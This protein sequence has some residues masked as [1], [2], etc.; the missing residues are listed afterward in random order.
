MIHG[1]AQEGKDPVVLKKEWL[2][3]LMYGLARANVKLPTDTTIEFPFYGDLLAKLVVEVATPLG[4]EINAKGPNP[5]TEN[6]L[7]GEMLTE[8]AYNAGITEADIRRELDDIP[9][10]RSP[11]NWEWVQ[12]ILRAFDRVPGLNSR[13]ID[14]FTRDTYVYLTIPG[15]RRQIDKVVADAL[16]EGPCIVLAHSLG[17]IIAYNVLRSRA[18]DPKYP[19]LITVGSPLGIRAIRTHL[20]TPLKS[21]PCIGNWFNAY[22]DRDLVALVPLDAVNFNVIPAIDNKNDVV[23]FTDNRHGITGYL[24]DPIIASKIAEFL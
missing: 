16:G 18:V 7:R 2:D 24:A 4:K 13:V 9:I 17:S 23:N 12:A 11:G 5:D 15:V 10:A 8:I 21:P 20:T 14:T 6:E 19:R 3:A 1:R 22:D